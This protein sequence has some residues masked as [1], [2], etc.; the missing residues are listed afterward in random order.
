MLSF[1]GS[2]PNYKSEFCCDWIFY[3]NKTI[4]TIHRAVAVAH[5]YLPVENIR[6]WK[7]Q[8]CLLK[9]F[10]LS[11]ENASLVKEKYLLLEK[12]LLEHKI[13]RQ[14][15]FLTS[16]TKEFSFPL[17]IYDLW[18][19]ADKRG[20]LQSLRICLYGQPGL[21]VLW[22]LLPLL[23]IYSSS[24]MVSVSLSTKFQLYLKK[25]CV[26]ILARF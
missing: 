8:T 13:S 15:T 9:R 17:K 21:C 2:K 10:A 4:F 23:I 16:Y 25:N 19:S 11:S 3:K 26:T 7:I 5:I 18:D 6:K 1:K 14:Y 12:M 24:Q 20:H 22:Q